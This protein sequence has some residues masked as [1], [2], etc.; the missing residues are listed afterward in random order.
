VCFCTCLFPDPVSR[1]HREPG[2]PRLTETCRWALTNPHLS[3]H[4]PSASRLA[5][6]TQKK[7]NGAPRRPRASLVST[8]S[9][10]HLLLRVPSFSRWPL[11]LHFFAPDVH[12]VWVR[13]CSTAS[14]PVREGLQVK[15]DFGGT[16]PRNVG[17]GT[18][19]AARPWGIHAL[20]LDY[21]P[22]RDYVGK[23]QS[24]FEF[25]R[26]GDCVVCGERQAPEE[27]LY[28]LCTNDG[29]EGVG[30]LSCWSRHLLREETGAGDSILPR[31]GRCPSCHGEVRW[32]DM[33][34][35]LTLRMRG[36]KDVEKLLKKPRGA[37]AARQV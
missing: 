5:V 37:K 15:T 34:K 22:I 29:C 32:D 10:L 31:E 16:T 19:E 25:E 1:W 17:D 35:E 27:G 8:L 7:Q 23:G 28:A 24:I 36:Q 33:M 4:I 6:S 2:S 26:E 21:A 3:M 13:W 30:H 14:E 11:T 12:T 18:D 20:P 9:N